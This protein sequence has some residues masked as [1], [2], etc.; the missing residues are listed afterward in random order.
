MKFPLDLQSI[1]FSS[2]A[3][4]FYKINLQCNISNNVIL[5][6]A[7]SL[8]NLCT[9]KL[10]FTKGTISRHGLRKICQ[11]LIH[12]ITLEI[13]SNGSV[14][15]EPDYCPEANICNLIKLRRIKMF[16]LRHCPEIGFNFLK[17]KTQMTHIDYTNSAN[18]MQFSIF[19]SYFCLGISIII[20]FYLL[21]IV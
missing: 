18:V 8:P 7:S 14:D 12:L 4:K 16:G 2:N 11:N 3:F 6:I 19:F 10:H 9:L 1:K 21:F 17:T 5:T 13:E 15:L 20:N